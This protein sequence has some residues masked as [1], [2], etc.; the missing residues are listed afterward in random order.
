M[1]TSECDFQDRTSVA[2]I[3][4]HDDAREC[5]ERGGIIPNEARKAY[6]SG[7]NAG[8]DSDGKYYREIVNFEFR[9]LARV[10]QPVT[11]QCMLGPLTTHYSGTLRI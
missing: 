10:Q 5:W 1:V 6:S 2:W 7:L 11:A 4:W 3:R 9:Q 8:I